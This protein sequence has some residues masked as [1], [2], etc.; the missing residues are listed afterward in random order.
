MRKHFI[1]CDV[2][3]D[4]SIVTI[5]AYTEEDGVRIPAPDFERP[6][7]R[8]TEAEKR[9]RGLDRLIDD[10]EAIEKSESHDQLEP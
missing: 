2:A 7:T 5:D 9:R 3:V 8:L 6:L 10:I 4:G 1:G